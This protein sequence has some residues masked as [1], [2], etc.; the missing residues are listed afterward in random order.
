[1]RTPVYATQFKR[2]VKK[3]TQRGHDIE[4]LKTV[5][6]LL[7]QE[8]PLPPKYKDHALKGDWKSYRELHIAPDW[9]LVYKIEGM[10][11]IFT[12]TGTHADLFSE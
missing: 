9:L 3:T 6:A 12:R 11:C 4:Q 8:T 1:M 5:A 2:D 10:D 7:L